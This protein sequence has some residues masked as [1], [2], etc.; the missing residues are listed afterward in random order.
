[1][2]CYAPDP[3]GGANSIPQ[4]SWVDFGERK[5]KGKGREREEFRAVV[6]KTLHIGPEI[7]SANFIKFKF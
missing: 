4:T 5:G 7:E 2:R 6:G 1:M 3:A